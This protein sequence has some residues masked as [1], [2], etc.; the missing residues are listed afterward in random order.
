MLHKIMYMHQA[1][2]MTQGYLRETCRVA[3]LECNLSVYLLKESLLSNLASKVGILFNLRRIFQLA[4][5]H[6]TIEVR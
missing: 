2:R 6:F 5:Y 3:I 4:V 1:L